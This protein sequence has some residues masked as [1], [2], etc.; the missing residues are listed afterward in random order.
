MKKECGVGISMLF[1]PKPL[2]SPRDMH[3]FENAW[4]LHPS[5][6]FELISTVCG[7]VFMPLTSSGSKMS[8]S[9]PHVI[10]SGEGYSL[11]SPQYSTNAP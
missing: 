6:S 5:V 3:F 8:N 7:Y 11:N 10:L 1:R 2:V 9:S 4:K